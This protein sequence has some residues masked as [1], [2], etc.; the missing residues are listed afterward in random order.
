MRFKL[1][2]VT[3]IA[4]LLSASCTHMR[5]RTAARTAEPPMA[6]APSSNQMTDQRAALGTGGAGGNG[7]SA[8]TRY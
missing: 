4:A 7:G 5:D 1:L 8:S 2:T 6:A 3:V